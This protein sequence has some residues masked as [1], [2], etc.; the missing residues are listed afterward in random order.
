MPYPQGVWIGIMNQATCG[1]CW[2]DGT[3]V[4]YLNWA[5]GHGQTVYDST[6]C[7]YYIFGNGYLISDPI[8]SFDDTNYTEKWAFSRN[9][10]SLTMRSGIC[11]KNPIF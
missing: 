7:D 2:T 11:K 4:N 5:P 10:C 9:N 3:P 1:I 6:P 8:K